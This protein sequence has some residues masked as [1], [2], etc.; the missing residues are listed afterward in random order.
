MRL[1]TERLV[2]GLSWHRRLGFMLCLAGAWLAAASAGAQGNI[3]RNG[4]FE[5]AGTPAQDWSQDTAKTGSKG[6]ISRD[7]VKFRSGGSSL[8]LQP[9]GNN[10]EPQLAVSQELPL[11]GLR[12]K[13]VQLSAWM[14][15]EGEAR[16][17]VGLIAIVGGKF[18][19]FML[20]Q[21]AG[22]ADWRQESRDYEVP[23]DPQ[24]KYYLAI[25]VDGR[26]G[27]A[28]FDDLAVGLPGAPAA[29]AAPL[30]PAAGILK[31]Q[32]DVD[33]TEV[34]RT[35]PR[36][37]YGANVEWR[38][39]ATYM[40][41]EETQS[42]D[43]V[44]K[45]LTREMGV[46]LIRYP[47]GV[48]SDFYNWRDGI[49]PFDKR[50]VVKHE[51]GKEDKTRPLFG[52]EE[53]IAFARDVGG[54]LMI[55]VNAGTGTAQS[56]ADWVRH[57]N[58]KELRV[59]YWEVGNELY[60]ND[61]SPVSKA[62]TIPPE[63]YAARFLE[64]AAAMRAA[65]PRIKIGAIG[66]ENYGR[67]ATV[68]YPN[69]NRTVF[70]RA[71]QEIDFLSV[72]N[73]YAPLISDAE[74]RSKD[75]RTI[76]RSMLAAPVLMAKNLETLT[77][78]L[79]QWGSPTRKPFLAVTEWGPIFQ[80][81]HKGR[82]VDHPKT[83]G[84]ALFAASALKNF[85]ESPRTDIAAFWMLNDF[86]VLG[87]LSSVNG[88]FPPNPEWA[89]T[90]RALAFQMFTRHFGERLVRTRSNGPTFDSETVG[91]TEAVHG[92]P[93]LDVVSS[94]S[95]DGRQ[96]YIL[97]IN[98][99]FDQA[100]DGTIGL[101]GFKPTGQGTAWTL[102]GAGI[103]AHLGSTVIRVPGLVWGKQVED[104]GHQRFGKGGPGEVTLVSAPIRVAADS[105][106]YRF[107]AHSITSLVLTRQ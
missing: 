60:I 59:R 69:W 23:D 40:W 63:K 7:M 65:D 97:A 44:G 99:D 104:T 18:S 27:S 83:L 11:A 47:G 1:G 46:A 22:S 57:V 45:R 20:N 14:A 9:N 92:A 39:N 72:H 68:S 33:A 30:V 43:P 31:A 10:R 4:G 98:K 2:A 105:F 100:I 25:W 81:V 87:W 71:G 90:A 61:G 94:V 8:R 106:G 54:E 79:E 82:Y 75:L 76:Y 42:P 41:R 91:I 58:A 26:S 102:N 37:L 73:A 52:T 34:V 21:V 66:G 32:V 29:V 55:T 84:S 67:Y 62:T 15:A 5:R 64:F 78:Q 38:W 88:N 70:E 93:L 13:A 86:S 35:I 101:K 50:P 12:G 17:T 28:W 56:A 36:T 80:W 49:G 95:T 6:S 3:V 48:Y 107:P 96:L 74:E 19:L 103:D 53:A 89:M 16:A 24:G 77:R 51:P 85:I